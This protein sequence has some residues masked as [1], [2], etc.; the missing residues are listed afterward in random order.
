MPTEKN[1]GISYQM[2]RIQIIDAIILTAILGILAASLNTDRNVAAMR[3]EHDAEEK[4]E[5][6]D[7]VIRQSRYES[8]MTIVKARMENTNARVERLEKTRQ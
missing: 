4:M 7:P 8:D 2:R 5:A 3:A 6:R 1:S